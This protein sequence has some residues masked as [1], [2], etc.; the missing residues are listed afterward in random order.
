MAQLDLD[1]YFSLCVLW[2]I[3]VNVNFLSH[4]KGA[5]SDKTAWS[6]VIFGMMCPIVD[7][8]IG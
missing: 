1:K 8:E 4:L 6:P 2:F 3:S 7:V 5:I